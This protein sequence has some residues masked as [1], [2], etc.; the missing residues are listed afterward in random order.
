[1]SALLHSL[2]AEISGFQLATAS[3]A[4]NENWQIATLMG[5]KVIE[6]STAWIAGYDCVFCCLAVTRNALLIMT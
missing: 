5:W 4:L 3:R 1:M 6:L 2:T